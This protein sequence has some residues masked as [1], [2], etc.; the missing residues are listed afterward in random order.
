[1][2]L[3]HLKSTC[4]IA[5]SAL[6]LCALLS[7][8]TSN[9]ENAGHDGNTAETSQDIS[10]GDADKNDFSNSNDDEYDEKY[11]SI[12]TE[13]FIDVESDGNPHAYAGWY[14]ATIPAGWMIYEN[15]ALF[16]A[17]GE[18]DESTISFDICRF[19]PDV[20]ENLDAAMALWADSASQLGDVTIG[21]LQWRVLSNP[22]TDGT[23]SHMYFAQVSSDE[24]VQISVDAHV[25]EDTANSIISS[26]SLLDGNP[27][28]N[29][30]KWE[31]A[32]FP[33]EPTDDIPDMDDETFYD[34]VDYFDTELDIGYDDDP[35]GENDPY[36]K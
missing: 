15:E 28:S 21:A 29:W 10:D 1:M 25:P 30:E 14:N 5:I 17:P 6:A 16:E 18:L 13:H 31:S 23:V 27:Y 32:Y 3:S 8:T 7:C 36:A 22:E 11:N 9:T 20:T 24:Y 2:P 26:F 19:E 33:E 34:D 12:S 4:A 35:E